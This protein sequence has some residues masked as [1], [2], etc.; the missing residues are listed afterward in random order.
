MTRID[1]HHL[2]LLCQ[3]PKARE[4]GPVKRVLRDEIDT[5]EWLCEARLLELS[6][7]A[8]YCYRR[9]PLGDRVVED[10]LLYA[11]TAMSAR[12]VFDARF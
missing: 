3:T 12:G 7:E 9:T 8:D 11:D 1:P 6:P 2:A 4:R 5:A 10:C